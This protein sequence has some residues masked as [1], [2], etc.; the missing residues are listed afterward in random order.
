MYRVTRTLVFMLAMLLAWPSYSAAQV[1]DFFVD[2]VSGSE[3]DTINASNAELVILSSTAELVIVAA[4][5]ND[6]NDVILGDT[7]VDSNN[8]VFVDGV[9][10]GSV[11]FYEDGDG[12]RSLFWVT[13]TGEVV[14]VDVFGGDPTSSGTLPTDYI[15]L[16]CNDGCDFWDDPNACVIVDPVSPPVTFNICGSGSAFALSAMLAGLVALRTARVRRPY[17]SE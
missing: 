5:G 4:N 9:F 7:V 2:P 17:V 8:S 12:L 16:P 1:W 13:L 11:E 14:E 3:C 15:G 6:I 10:R